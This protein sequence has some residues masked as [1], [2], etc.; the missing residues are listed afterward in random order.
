MQESKQLTPL[1]RQY[2]DIKSKNTDLIVFFRLGDFYEMFDSD[3]REASRI[4]GI[5]LTQRG[6]VPMCGV[7]YHAAANYISKIIKEG[8]KVGICEQ[9]GTG[10][11]KSKLFERKI[12]RVITPGTVIEDN[13]LQSNVSNYL[14]CV[15]TDKKGWG[16]AAIDVSTGEFWVTEQA[17]DIS[18]NGLSCMLA[19]LNPAEILLDKITLDRVKSSMMIPGSVATTIVPREES[20][21]IPSNWP[22][23]SVWAGKK[24]ALTCALTAIKY[25]NVNEPGFK[26]LLIPFYKE[27]SDY[28]AL[29]ENAVRT[30]ELVSQNGARKGSLWHLLDFTVTPMGGRTLKNWILNPLLNL[31]DIEKRQNCVSNFYDNPLAYEELKVILADIS[32]IERIMSRVGTGNA[33]PRDLAG[34]ARSLAVH[35]ALKNWFDKYGAVVPYLKE[36]ILS[37]ITVIEDLANLLNSAIEPNPP[38]KI[39]DGGIIKQGFNA[40]LDDLRNTKNN[41]SKTLAELCER[42]KA[43][44]GI[45]TLKV[46]FNSVF[47][48]YIEVSKGQSGKVP[49]SY[50]RKQTLTNAERFITEELKEIEDKIL[51]AEEKILRLETSLFDSVRKHL[52]EHIGVMRSFAK[53]IAELDVYSNLAHCAKVYKFT[54]PVIDESN[55]LK[56]ADLRHPVVE[57]CLPL[58][59]FVPN[60]IDLGGETQISVITGPNMGGKSVYL[61]QAAVLVILAQMGS[62]VPAAS[63]HVGIVDKIMTRIGAQDAI[64]M[65]QSTFM[66]EMKETSHIL[67]SC[68]PKSLI[69]LDEVG[70]GTSTFDGISIAWA[71]TE[72]LYKPH[73]GGAKVLFAT[74]YFELTDLENK[75]KGIKNFHAEVQEYKDADGQSKIAFLYKIKE[76]AGDKSYGIHVGELA[77]LPATVIVRAK[78]VIKDLEAKKGTSVSKK[79]DDIVGDLFSSPI[80]E[81]IKL[82]NTDAVTPMQ[83]LQMILEWKKRI[84][85]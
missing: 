69:L 43:K 25:I 53:A 2:N 12:V 22:S 67:A 21:Q 8:R 10:E 6:G 35:G 15:F 27:I 64:A 63:A 24:T 19:A 14:V 56:A 75:Y 30:L 20:S 32:D 47:G 38:I 59:S 39:S 57:A 80:V 1:M 31:A 83:A 78:K 23:Q 5:A 40:E 81:E 68:T 84:N 37:K 70:R 66:V 42:E 18:L 45:S 48:Y 9:V 28:L 82:V 36:N 3:A 29:D 4:L 49:F 79:E 61:K 26:D 41:S 55:I 50:T 62:F 46:G 13:M 34:L 54:K 60:D 58:G 16:A 33:G 77:G 73:G 7:P 72:F 52:A 71:I 85:S 74:H 44:T 76:G 17:D 51:H 65:G 11:G